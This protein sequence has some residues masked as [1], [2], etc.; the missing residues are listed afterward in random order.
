[1]MLRLFCALTILLLAAPAHATK[2]WVKST[3]TASPSCASI[4]G[5]A[6]PGAYATT[7]AYVWNNCITGGDT[8]HITGNL[9]ASQFNL[10][11]A[12]NGTEGAPTVVEGDGMS[13][14]TITA[15]GGFMYFGNLTFSYVEFRDFT[16]NG[17][18]A[19][20]DGIG[21]GLSPVC[22][23]L[24][25]RR[26]RI[27]NYQQDGVQ[28]LCDHLYV[29]ESEFDNLGSASTNQK[30]A[31]YQKGD[32]AIIEYSYFH[33]NRGGNAVQCYRSGSD[34]ADRCIIRR[35][36]FINNADAITLDGNDDQVYRNI[37]A[38]NSLNAIKC[39]YPEGGTGCIRPKIVHNIIYN[40]SQHGIHM[41]LFGA[42]TSAT[43]QN[44]I[45]IA[46]GGTEI[47]LDTSSGGGTATA[48]THNACTA[49]ETCG[50]SK[51]TIAAITDCTTSTSDFTHKAGGS[52][53]NVGTTVAGGFAKNGSAPDIGPFEMAEFSSCVV[54]NGDA[55]VMRVSF[56]NNVS[57]PLL[58]SSN[59]D[60]GG[61][62]TRKAGAANAVTATTRTGDNR[63]DLALTNAIVNGNAI[64]VT[65][66]AGGQGDLTASDLIGNSLNQPYRGTI[67]QQSCTN[68][69]G[70]ASTYLFLQ[71]AYE[72][73]GYRGT[74]ADPVMLRTA[75]GSTENLPIKPMPGAKARLRLALTNST[76]DAPPTGFFLY[77]SHNGGAYGVVPDTFGS[78]NVKFCG[79]DVDTDVP[80]NQTATTDQLST[81]GTFVPGLLVL[82]SNAIPSVDLDDSP[83]SKTELEYC[84]AWDTD[85]VD[86]DTN[87]FR[88]YKSDGTAIDTYTVTPRATVQAAGG[89]GGF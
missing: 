65:Y 10:T 11:T 75:G 25:F 38:G 54:E 6:D 26:V 1:M 79:T 63:V 64:D 77:V 84:L 73:H 46:N 42:G 12:K 69:V 80:A 85:A 78:A 68:N 27:T 62:T 58:P 21:M 41:G 43:I 60:T 88:L 19:A 37:F 44:N 16:V 7:V 3:G 33:D 8:I 61:F 36:R 71:A 49:G 39:G 35:N 13:S 82:T 66:T 70:A 32:D 76:A 34:N 4:D 56:E 57:P 30:H 17:S 87:D 83:A 81:S 5:D 53:L 23:H 20:N 52:C 47:F 2:Y 59:A 55:S 9:T 40:N 86:G 14:T 31:I 18:N 48:N 24:T 15:S 74:E 67:S 45:V 50:S 72:W 51:I 29:T 89:G 22:H 28:N